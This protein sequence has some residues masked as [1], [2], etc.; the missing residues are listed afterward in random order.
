MIGLNQERVMLMMRMKLMIMM[1]MIGQR[2]RQMRVE[3]LFCRV[4]KEVAEREKVKV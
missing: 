1:M 2:E 4:L 3:M